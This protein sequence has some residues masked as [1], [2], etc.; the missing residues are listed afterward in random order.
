M[1]YLTALAALLMLAGCA[2]TPVP[3]SQ[4]TSAPQDRLFGSQSVTADATATAVV[5]RDAGFVNGGCY[6]SLYINGVR[7]AALAQK[8]V[9]TFHLQPGR[10]VFAAVAEG[11]GMCG[12]GGSRREVE[13]HINAHETR[14]YRI[15]IPDAESGPVV[16]PST[17]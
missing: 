9:A 3:A 14:A 12:A 16:Q 1:K 2:T 11:N 8:E 6:I 5:S 10:L 7:V 13:T 17:L 15:S 4:Q